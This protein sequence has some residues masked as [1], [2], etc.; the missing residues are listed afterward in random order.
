M[1]MGRMGRITLF[2]LRNFRRARLQ[3]WLAVLAATAGTGGIVVSTDYAAAGREKIFDQFRR[4]GTNI[5]IV[6]PIESRSVGGRARTGAL[7]TTLRR[8]DYRAVIQQVPEIV[9]SSPTV[10]TVLRVR[11]GDL[12]KST[13]VVGCEPAYFAIRNWTIQTGAMFNAV[14]DR[15]ERRVAL[16]GAAAARDLFGESDPAGRRISIG[17][18]PF[19][20]AGVLRERGQGLDAAN[21]DAQ[22]YVPLATAMRRLTNIDYYASILL[23]IGSWQDMDLAAREIADIV[24]RRHRSLSFTGPD[25]RVQNQKSL[26]ETQL[27]TFTRLTFFLR[28][29]AASTAMVASVGIFGIAWIGVGH[30]RREIGTCRAIGATMADVILQFFVE[31]ITGPVIGCAG[32]I[33]ISWP[34]LRAIDLRVQQPFLFSSR[35]AVEAALV[36]IV[37]YAG[38]SIT[39]AWRAIRVDPSAAM[40]A[41]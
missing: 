10:S 31:G 40:R 19:T 30:R 11:A 18:E 21:E 22:I 3:G 15:S 39:C 6:T 17:R 24:N 13:I 41:D 29:I 1:T 20:V 33:A 16:L 12:T 36:S 23:E 14:D 5:V 28:W 32:G 27:A 25:F 38:S 4:M 7:V 2:G 34:V 37:L 9:A 35:L 8:S 26:I